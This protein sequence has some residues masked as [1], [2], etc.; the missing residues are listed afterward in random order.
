MKKLHY[1]T[2]TDPVNYD[3]IASNS[4]RHLR[5]YDY[6]HLKGVQF[7]DNNISWADV[8]GLAAL[9]LAVVSIIVVLFLG[10]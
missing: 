5:Y 6:K 1:F 2:N 4:S 9:I 10:V 8:I 3:V 7:T